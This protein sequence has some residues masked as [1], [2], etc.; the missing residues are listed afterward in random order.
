MEINDTPTPAHPQVD[1]TEIAMLQ[2]DFAAIGVQDPTSA[3]SNWLGKPN[4]FT[5]Q[6]MHSAFEVLTYFRAEIDA[7]SRVAEQPREDKVEDRGQHAPVTRNEGP[8]VVK[9]KA[10]PALR[11]AAEQAGEAWRLAVKQRAAAMQQWDEY[12]RGLSNAYKA[13]RAAAG[14]R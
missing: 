1:P 9:P 5:A 2:S 11:I 8:A 13:A 14:L 7:R 10:D 12:V 6:V 3:V 4:R